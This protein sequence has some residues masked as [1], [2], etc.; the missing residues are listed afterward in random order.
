MPLPDGAVGTGRPRRPWLLRAGAAIVVMVIAACGGSGV[1]S[2]GTTNA[3]QLAA[4]QQACA[5]WRTAYPQQSAPPSGWCPEMVSWM[6]AHADNGN[7]MWAGPG[8]MRATCEQWVSSS[9]PGPARPSGS[10]QWCEQM[11]AWMSQYA[12]QWGSWSGWMRHGPMTG[13]AVPT[14]C[15]PP[16][17]PGTIVHVTLLSMGS[18]MMGG[19]MMGGRTMWLLSDRATVPA[20]TVSLVAANPSPITHELVVLPL[21]SDQPV[22]ERPVGAGNTVSETGSLGEASKACGAGAGDGITA[23]SA[24]W[25]TLHLAPGRYELVCNLPGHY[26]AGMY[27]PLTRK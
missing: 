12:G 18:P 20:G 5:Q 7:A 21:T 13:G 11:V 23:G 3:Q 22:G 24:G 27:A 9:S 1:G 17:L 26:A 6:S 25:V 2:S 14:A 19:P 8:A 16:G 15:A 4:L 10:S